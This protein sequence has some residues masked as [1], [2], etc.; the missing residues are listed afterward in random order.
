[1]IHNVQ[2]RRS[3]HFLYITGAL[4]LQAVMA[5]M[6]LTT[7]VLA[8]ASL[9]ASFLSHD[10]VISFHPAL[11]TTVSSVY[12]PLIFRPACMEITF[13]P[14]YGSFLD[15]QGKVSCIGVTPGTHHVTVYIRVSGG[16]WTKPYFISPLTTIRSDG[17]W[18]AD[19]TTGGSDQLATE[20]AA[21]LV[22]NGYT[23]PLMAGAAVLPQELYAN[24]ATYIMVTRRITR[25]ISFAG[26]TWEVKFTP[27][28]AGPG[29]NFFSDDPADVWVD[30]N[31]YLHMNIISRKGTWYSTEVI[32]TDTLQYGAYTITLGSR[33]D[34]LDKNV[35]VGFFSWDTDAPQYNYREID[36]EFSRWGEDGAQNAQYVIQPWDISGNRHRYSMNLTGTD[37]VHR[38]D[39]RSDRIE[40]DSWDGNDTLLQSW[41]Y[42]NTSYIPPAGAGNARINLWLL[43][44]WS[45]SDNQNVEV[46]V[47]SFQFEPA[48]P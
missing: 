47:K 20:I 27:T 17:T 23:P 14:P 22:P 43:N 37:S 9:P 35:V 1:M 12:L 34:M 25:T 4:C 3:Q 21:F 32:C 16:W 40:F 44:G 28:P 8:S 11:T 26:Y 6:I 30:G 38:F 33:V 15:L 36:V 48:N 31:G 13:L 41:T 29:P 19:I 39:W 10:S 46:I 42:T 24:A 5:I 2:T 7:P 45:P 18:T